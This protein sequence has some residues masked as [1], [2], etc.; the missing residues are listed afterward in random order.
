VRKRV[1]IS[2]GFTSD[3]MKMWREFFKAMVIGQ[4]SNGKPITFR[5][6]NENCSKVQCSVIRNAGNGLQVIQSI[7]WRHIIW[8]TYGKRLRRVSVKLMRGNI[9]R[10]ELI[11]M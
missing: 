6:S 9:V 11:T 3:W 5:L 8:K 2:F 7:I 10:H 1:T 4:R